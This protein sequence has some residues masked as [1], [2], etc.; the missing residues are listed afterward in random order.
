MI[1]DDA[2]GRQGPS[3]QAAP[4]STQPSA[5]ASYSGSTYFKFRGSKHRVTI[6]MAPGFLQTQGN[7]LRHAKMTLQRL[8]T[9]EHNAF[10]AGSASANL[11]SIRA[12]RAT[13]ERRYVNCLIRY[14][15]DANR[16]SSG[17]A[18]QLQHSFTRA[19]MS[20]MLS[21][22]DYLLGMYPRELN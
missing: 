18:T 3:R 9:Q 8:Y 14:L 12:S 2:S 19:R 7:E 11:P 16:M 15:R 21:N 4:R 6:R 10:R 20:A 5:Y 13:A 22:E 17:E 1:M